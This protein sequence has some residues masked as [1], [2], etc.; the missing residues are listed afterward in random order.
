MIDV[1]D[2][3]AKGTHTTTHLRLFA[4]NE[5]FIKT[6]HRRQSC[7]AHE[8]IAAAIRGLTRSKNPI[9]IKHPDIHGKAGTD[10]TAM[11]PRSCIGRV[12]LQFSQR[13][14]GK[15]GIKNR[16]AIEK[17]DQLACGLTPA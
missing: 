17:K 3:P 6:T 1:L 16:V 15:I 2:V 4:G 14:E 7:V 9:E 13:G 5:C 8:H 10:L 11:A 12:L